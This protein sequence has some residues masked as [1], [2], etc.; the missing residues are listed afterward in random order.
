MGTPEWTQNGLQ[1]RTRE[2]PKTLLEASCRGELFS[3]K[4]WKRFRPP[5]IIETVFF[6]RNKV[7]FFAK[8]A[9]RA[10]VAKI[11]SNNDATM[12][13]TNAPKRPPDAP[14]CRSKARL[15][16][17]SNS[18]TDFHDFR[19]PKWSPKSFKNI[20]LVLPGAPGP[21]RGVQG[22]ILEPCWHHFGPSGARKPR[23]IRGVI[24]WKLRKPRK[25]RGVLGNASGT[26]LASL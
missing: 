24:L 6:V 8:I 14:Q 3:D 7:F 23:T 15:E 12:E 18:R 25:L 5:G 11:D 13:P 4:C 26:I 9:P 21:P 22:A 20:V 2:A 19:V 17:R 16:I 10:R 1:N